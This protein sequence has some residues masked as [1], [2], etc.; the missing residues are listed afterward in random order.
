M[1][2]PLDQADALARAWPRAEYQV[3]ADAGHSALEPGT[4]DALVGATDRMAATLGGGRAVM[5]GLLQ[6]VTEARVTVSG[7]TVGAIES[8]LLVLVGVE[9]GDG[10]AQA[11]RLAERLV[12]YRVFADDAG[13][14]NRSVADT[15]GAMLLVPQFTLAANTDKGTRASF[16]SAAE[17]ERG[18]ELFEAL[19]AAVHEAGVAVETGRF[20]ADMQV[21]SVNDGP[22]TFR[23]RVAPR[24]ENH[25]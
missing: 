4:I 20:G 25:G 24:T 22:V 8:G 12:G 9:R 7:E 1:I 11:A 16:A 2:S 14:M 23:L 19:V 5:I 6:R 15:G 3:I 21:A 10:P 18:L 17:S 13:R